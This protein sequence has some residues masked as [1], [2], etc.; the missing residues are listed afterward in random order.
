MGEQVKKQ[1]FYDVCGCLMKVE[2]S[3]DFFASFE[4]LFRDFRV[5]SVADSIASLEVIP[6][7]VRSDSE[8]KVKGGLHAV[9]FSVK[10]AGP[11]L[12]VYDIEAVG[13][14]RRLVVE[15]ARFLLHWPDKC[16]VHASAL[17]KDGRTFVFF[18]PGNTGKT[19]LGLQLMSRGYQLLGDDWVILGSN[20]TVYRFPQPMRV[21]DYNLA[22]NLNWCRELYG[23]F[24]VPLHYYMKL[25]LSIRNWLAM[26]LPSRGLRY[27]FDWAFTRPIAEIDVGDLN[28]TAVSDAP[29]SVGYWLE[30]VSELSDIQISKLSPEE[31]RKR[32]SYT[33]QY[34]LSEFYKWYFSQAALG[35]GLEQVDRSIERLERSVENAVRD[36]PLFKIR[37]PKEMPPKQ[38]LMHIEKTAQFP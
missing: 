27:L 1:R 32:V 29:I 5:D 15:F 7:T 23:S 19:T 26:R 9:H 24:G 18:A 22:K 11:I 17:Q 6:G 14:E 4:K 13:K 8:I 12:L 28:G 35:A 37:I 31:L 21:H 2:G 16:Q 36:V 25:R 33:Y 10:A 34:E 3:D 20:G 30:R 38:L